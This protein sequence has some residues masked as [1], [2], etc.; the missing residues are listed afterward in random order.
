M[1]KINAKWNAKDRRLRLSSP[2]LWA[3]LKKTKITNVT[4]GMMTGCSMIF[5]GQF[6]KRIAEDIAGLDEEDELHFE[7]ELI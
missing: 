4:T 6:E 5:V 1:N 3:R 7:D 2:Y